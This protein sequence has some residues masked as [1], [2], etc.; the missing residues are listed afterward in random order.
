M[1][2]S[3]H[4]LL[5]ERWN[6]LT[7]DVIRTGTGGL[8]TANGYRQTVVSDMLEEIAALLVG[9]VFETELDSLSDAI[10]GIWEQ[11]QDRLVDWAV[12]IDANRIEYVSIKVSGS[13]A[14]LP[15]S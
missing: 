9:G 3:A 8:S 12:A 5:D 11:I 1:S 4:E 14:A 7:K 2:V 13:E 15:T 6:V 10:D